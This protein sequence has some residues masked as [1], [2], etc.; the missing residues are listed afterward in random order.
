MGGRSQRCEEYKY[1]VLR[2]VRSS[3]SCWFESIMDILGFLGFFSGDTNSMSPKLAAWKLPLL[4][5][6][7]TNFTG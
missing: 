2:T 4:I 6:S 3:L 1:F 5:V 7:V